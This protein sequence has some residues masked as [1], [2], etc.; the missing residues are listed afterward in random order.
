[1]NELVNEFEV[2]RLSGEEYALQSG[3]VEFVVNGV[4]FMVSVCLK[5]EKFVVEG[6]NV[7]W[8]ELRRML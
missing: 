1:M 8:V 5:I 6:S 7:G 2:F 3:G 4:E